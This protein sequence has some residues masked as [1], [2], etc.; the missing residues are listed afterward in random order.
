MDSDTESES[1]TL[2]GPPSSSSDKVLDRHLNVPR[3]QTGLIEFQSLFQLQIGVSAHEA[4]D[5]LLTETVSPLRPAM[6]ACRIR[7]G[8][9]LDLEGRHIS[10]GQGLKKVLIK[11]CMSHD[12]HC[13]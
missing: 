2:W 11:T 13:T 8:Q 1:E 9:E 3:E 6:L 10:S 5:K 7:T 12:I 4:M